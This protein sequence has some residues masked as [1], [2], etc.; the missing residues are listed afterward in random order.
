MKRDTVPETVT[1]TGFKTRAVL[2]LMSY[3]HVAPTELKA[4]ACATCLKVFDL[5]IIFEIFTE[6]V[7]GFPVFKKYRG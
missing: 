3:K 7:F 4:Q 1:P 6:Q 5:L 2:P